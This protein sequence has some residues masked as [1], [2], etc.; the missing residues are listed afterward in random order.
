MWHLRLFVWKVSRK[1]P[2]EVPTKSSSH[3]MEIGYQDSER[4]VLISNI[5]GGNIATSTI[6]VSQDG[7]HSPFMSLL[8]SGCP[9]R[10]NCPATRAAFAP[11]LWLVEETKQQHMSIESYSHN[12]VVFHTTDTIHTIAEWAQKKV[13]LLLLKDSMRMR[14]ATELCIMWRYTTLNWLRRLCLPREVCLPYGGGRWDTSG[15]RSFRQR[16][17][18]TAT[19]PRV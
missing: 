7:N 15:S 12:T 6:I 5:R 1:F 10:D 8:M 17:F 16:S 13:R 14:V 4:A 19:S 11:L 2:S 3:T 9:L 18:W